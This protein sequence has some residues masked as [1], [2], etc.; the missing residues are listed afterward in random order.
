MLGGRPEWTMERLLQVDDKDNE[1]QLV[2][3]FTIPVAQASP[4]PTL[5]PCPP[6]PTPP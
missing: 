2:S 1:D 4:R 6:H 5:T 3:V